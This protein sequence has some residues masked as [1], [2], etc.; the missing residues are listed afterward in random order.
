M[1][2][3]GIYSGTFDPVHEGHVAFAREAIRQ[4]GLDKVF[5]LVEPRPR[6]KQG[7]KALEHRAEMVHLAIK[8]EPK[9]GSIVLEQQRFTPV[10]TLPVLQERFKGTELYMLMGDD[11]LAH[12]VGW[13]H[14]EQ[15]MSQIR[16]AVGL[17][18]QTEKEVIKRLDLIQ[19]IR[20]QTMNYKLFQVSSPE[21]SS[22]RIRQAIKKGKEPI[23]LMAEVQVYIRKQ[24]L[25][26]D[27][28]SS[29]RS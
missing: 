15:L 24:G 4:C 10:D 8:N 23:G 5:F 7:V 27:K 16:F 19:K 9:F 13:P 26:S 3:V 21:F 17:R 29:I 6:R 25:Y 18:N 12:F 1:K 2:R 14:V 11:W 22:S 20:G 28:G